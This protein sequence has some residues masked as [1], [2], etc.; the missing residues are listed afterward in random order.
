MSHCEI[1][2][3]HEP[4]TGL[5][6]IVTLKE[7]EDVPHEF[8]AVQVTTVVPEENELPEAGTQLTE[9]AG[10]PV[11]DG[12]EYVTIGL[13]LEISE[14]QLPITGDSLIVTLNEHDDVRLAASVAVQV[15]TVVPVE[16]ELPLSGTQ[17]TIAPAQ[18]SVTVGVENVTTPLSHC[19]ISVGHAPIAGGSLSTTVT[20]KEQ[21][22]AGGNP[23]SAVTVTVVVPTGNEVPEFCEYVTVGVG[24]PVAF[25][26]E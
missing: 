5:S 18:L 19:S 15:T 8:V 12:V 14:G 10:E 17:F 25:A 6:L 11:E 23:L 3:G 7:Q 16:K 9:A 24:V 13:Q 26:A 20:V 21:V 1:S 22:A 2:E 4:I